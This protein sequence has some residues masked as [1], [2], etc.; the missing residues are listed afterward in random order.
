MPDLQ[1]EMQK[2]LSAWDAPEPT[3]QPEVQ[4]EPPTETPMFK[5]TNNTSRS[6][7]EI[8]RD[9]PGLPKAQYVRMLEAK[10]LKKSSTATLLSQMT[11]QGHLWVDSSGCLR[12][13]QLEYRPLVPAK[14][15]NKRNGIVHVPKAPKTPKAPK[16]H[17]K[18][19]T[20]EVPVSAG[21]TALVEEHKPKDAV[22]HIM[23]TI[24]LPDAKRLHKALSEYFGSV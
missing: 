13:N 5:T 16:A 8:V 10:G 14:T 17:K 20:K 15:F 21:I 4:P 23:D 6:T 2:I 11:K 24:S 1:T 9:N 3:T 12:T 22:Q 7:F 18:Y 19:K